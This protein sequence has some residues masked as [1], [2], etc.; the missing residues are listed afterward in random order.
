MSEIKTS[1]SIKEIAV[2]LAKFQGACG[3]IP[4]TKTNPHFKSKYAGFEDIVET[5]RKPLSENGLSFVQLPGDGVLTTVIMHE[6]GEYIQSAMTMK[7]AKENNPQAIGSALTYSKRYSLA[8][9]LGLAV[10]DEDDDG[11]AA[12]APSPKHDT[13]KKTL[14]DEQFKSILALIRKGEFT[15]EK[16]E[17]NYKLTETQQTEFDTFKQTADASA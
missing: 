16:T 5:I 2:A 10:G 3:T 12:A 8:S 6:S 14:T 11:N 7:A 1:D 9:I 4:K 15:T 17:T 13:P